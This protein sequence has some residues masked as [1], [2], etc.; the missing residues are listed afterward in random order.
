[1]SS[2][3]VAGF[4]LKGHGLLLF[5]GPQQGARSEVEQPGHK[6]TR[7]WMLALEE[8]ALL[9]LPQCWSPDTVAAFSFSHC[10][11]TITLKPRLK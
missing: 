9:I 4:K 3:W 2:K 1:M 6:I 10:Y 5:S 8:V 11:F 7:I